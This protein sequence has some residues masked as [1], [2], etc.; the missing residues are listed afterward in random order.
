MIRTLTDQILNLAPLPI[1]LRVH[2]T[3]SSF[4]LSL[5][6]TYYLQP[7]TSLMPEHPDSYRENLHYQSQNL[8]PYLLGDPAM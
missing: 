3:I 1:G 8:M 7:T 5:P 2:F 6:K 4:R